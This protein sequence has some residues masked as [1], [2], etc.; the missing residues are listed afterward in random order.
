MKI[1]L[2]LFF[3]LN[4]VSITPTFGL[5]IEDRNEYLFDVRGDDGD[6]Y[7]NRF[8]LSKKIHPLE[9]DII[10]FGETQ[11]NLKISDWEK[12]TAGLEIDKSLWKHLYIG[13]TIQF[14]SGQ[15]L[16]YAN[17]NP[18]N[19]SVEAMTKISLVFPLL[20]KYLQEKLYLRLFEEYSYNFEEGEAGLYEIGINTN[21]ALNKNFSIGFG[22][23]HTDRIHSFDSDYVSSSLTLRF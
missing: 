4:L 20:K 8:S 6:I 9:L 22:W 19:E 21:Y 18:G 3:I 11:W 1:A 16:D 14:I 13:E 12:N 10:A 5:E 23:H 17:F 15:L 7:L 2:S